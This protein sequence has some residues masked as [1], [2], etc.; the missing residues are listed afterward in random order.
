MFVYIDRKKKFPVTMLL[1]AI[2]FSAKRGDHH[3]FNLAETVDLKHDAK[4][5]LG[6]ALAKDLVDTGTGEV[7]AEQ[8]SEITESLL[9]QCKKM[10]IHELE[11]VKIFDPSAPNV[12]LNTLKRDN[13][14]NEEE[15][16]DSIYRQLRSGEPPDLDTARGLIERMFFNNKRYD[17]GAV[18]RYRMNKN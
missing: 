12:I 10:K 4:Q 9:A 14:R 11:V 3:L 2:G 8:G 7:I 15:A 1:R 16:I 17:M 5:N 18:G 13:T 6:R